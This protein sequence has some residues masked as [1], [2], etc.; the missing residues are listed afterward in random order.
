MHIKGPKLELVAALILVVTLAAG[1]YI[2]FFHSRGFV[3][4]TATIIEI[5]QESSADGDITYSATVEHVVDGKPYIGVLDSYSSSF[6]VGKA[7]Q[8]LYDPEDPSVIH[9]SD[10]MGIYLIVMSAGILVFL[11]VR[12]VRLGRL[13]QEMQERQEM[14]GRRSYAPSVEGEERELYFLT[15]LG[16]PKFGHRL[17]DKS[18]RVLYEAKMTKFSV[19]LPC[20]FDFIDHEHGSTTPHLVGQ[21]E[22]T[23]F[24]SVLIDSNST[25]EL[26]GEDIW[27]HLKRNGIR[28]ESSLGAGSGRVL[29]TDYRILRDGKEIARAQ[30][31]GQYPH[32]ED[33]AAHRVAGAI[34]VRG[35][36]RVWTKEE[37]LDLLFVTLLAFAR[38]GAMDD[39][40]GTYGAIGGTLKKF[41]QK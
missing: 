22:D 27:Q 32:E 1:V 28:V 16:T 38:T 18:R 4:S 29:G 23:E 33:A 9:A 34:P 14:S 21:E 2:T 11:A 24:S 17:E 7:V 25:F 30:S 26:D 31:T 3:K 10:G 36:C 35:F 40:G 6:R 41:V 37:N 12:R 20:S 19:S 5:Q 13:Q 8:I 39:R 15:D